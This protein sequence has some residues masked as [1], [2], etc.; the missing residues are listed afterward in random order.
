MNGFSPGSTISL[1]VIVNARWHEM[2]SRQLMTTKA[3]DIWKA[4]AWLSPCLT[5]LG[6]FSNCFELGHYTFVVVLDALLSFQLSKY[7]II[8]INLFK[9]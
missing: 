3:A 6:E 2:V 1:G 5:Q 9:D 4:K 7:H 8:L